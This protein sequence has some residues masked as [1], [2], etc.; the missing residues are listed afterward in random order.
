[1]PGVHVALIWILLA[2]WLAFG[3]VLL[4]RIARDGEQRTPRSPASAALLWIWYGLL[5]AAI[6]AAAADHSWG[7]GSWASQISPVV[8]FGGIGIIAAAIG[9]LG[10]LAARLRPSEA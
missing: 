8:L 6:F 7:L 9:E 10:E 2:L 3:P 5:Y 4:R 1:M